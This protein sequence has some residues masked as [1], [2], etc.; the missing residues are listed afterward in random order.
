MAFQLYLTQMVM[1]KMLLILCLPS[2]IITSCSYPEEQRLPIIKF[3]ERIKVINLTRGEK[4]SALFVAKN[5]GNETLT[6]NNV[7]ASCGCTRVE[8][9]KKK[10]VP[11]DSTTIRVTYD[12][13]QDNYQIG[14]ISKLIV[15][16]SN[17]LPRLSTLTLNIRATVAQ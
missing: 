17:T 9:L 12:N 8:Y 7:S 16:T 1:K 11:G 6:L 10:I 2:L 5:L 3:N 15:V 4:A 14:N 13:T